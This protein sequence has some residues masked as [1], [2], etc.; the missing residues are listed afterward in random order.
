MPRNPRMD[1]S[2]PDGFTVFLSEYF[3]NFEGIGA[4]CESGA[5]LERV[6]RLTV[7]PRFMPLN[8]LYYF[9]ILWARIKS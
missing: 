6:V 5:K 7:L 8:L 9:A 3:G 2:G 4:T 1:E